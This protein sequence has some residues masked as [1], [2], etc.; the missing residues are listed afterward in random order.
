M[1]REATP[2][3]LGAAFRARERCQREQRPDMFGQYYREEIG[4]D[5]PDEMTITFTGGRPGEARALIDKIN[6]ILPLHQTSMARRFRA[7]ARITSGETSEFP[8]AAALALQRAAPF[9]RYDSR[10]AEASAKAQSRC[11]R[12]G[13]HDA[14]TFT[15]YYK[16]E[17]EGA[18]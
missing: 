1:P 16:A 14:E 12:E 4:D 5:V 9:S 2:D 8:P 13:K 6:S 10:E 18:A 17:L 11:E 15:R 3:E 7:C